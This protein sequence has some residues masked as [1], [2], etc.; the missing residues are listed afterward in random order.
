MLVIAPSAD[1]PRATLYVPDRRDHRTHE[2]FTDARYGELWVGA[3]RGVAEAATYYEIDTAPLETP[4]ASDL[5]ALAAT[6]IVSCAD[7]T[8]RW[9][10]TSRRTRTTTPWPPRSASFAS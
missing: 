5:D 7:S 9:T 2:F 4:R 6:E 8:A 10:T 1:G 3:R